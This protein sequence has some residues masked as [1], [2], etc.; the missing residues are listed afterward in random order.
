M[1]RKSFTNAALAMIASMVLSAALSIAM[2]AAA[3]A[4]VGSAGPMASVKS[5]VDQ[6]TAVFKDQ[7]VPPAAREK[8]LRAIAESHFDF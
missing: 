1:V 4:D 6:A 2:R 3:I 8:K 7:N 5:V